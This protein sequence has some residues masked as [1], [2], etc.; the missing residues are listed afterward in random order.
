M[1][2]PRT[3]KEINEEYNLTAA[4]IGDA[5][6][7]KNL[8]CL[9]IEELLKKM[10]ELNDEMIPSQEFHRSKNEEKKS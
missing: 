5:V 1:A 9:H 8:A 3:P 7:R 10:R 2:N 6:F 4:K